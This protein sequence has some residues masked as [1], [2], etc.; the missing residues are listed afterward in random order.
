[1]AAD[2]HREATAKYGG[3]LPVYSS[4]QRACCLVVEPRRQQSGGLRLFACIPGPC[5]E[6]V[7]ES[8]AATQGILSARR[9]RRERGARGLPDARPADGLPTEG[10][11]TEHTSVG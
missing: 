6:R 11:R 5:A 2:D 4:V 1:M 9:F 10:H 8:R 7:T 3:S